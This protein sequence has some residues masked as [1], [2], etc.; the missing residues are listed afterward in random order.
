M[1]SAALPT[2]LERSCLGRVSLGVSLSVAESI[3]TIVGGRCQVKWPN[4]VVLNGRKVSGVLLQSRLEDGLL[5]RL[6]AGVGVNL[7]DFPVET[8]WPATSV[9]HATG[10]RVNPQPLLD[11]IL[12]RIAFWTSLAATPGSTELV[13]TWNSRSILI[14]SQVTVGEASGT[15]S[16]RFEGAGQFGQAMIRRPDGSVANIYSGDLRNRFRPGAEKEEN[17]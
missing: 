6:V 1:F 5:R 10:T 16:G 17:V 7:I 13:A 2:E 3:E 11:T 12:N 8:N 4:D 14:G 9:R 15:V